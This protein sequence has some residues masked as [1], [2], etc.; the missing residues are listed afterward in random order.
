MSQALDFDR[1]STLPM[2]TSNT[3]EPVSKSGDVLL[4]WAVLFREDEMAFCPT[5]SFFPQ[6]SNNT[7]LKGQENQ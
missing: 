7:I 6:Q 3:L 2:E 4:K 1:K 5:L